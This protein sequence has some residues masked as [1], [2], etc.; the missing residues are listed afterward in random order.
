MGFVM[1]GFVGNIYTCTLTEVFVNLTEVFLILTEGFPCL[2]LC[3]KANARVKLAKKGHGPHSST[4][5]ICVVKL[6]F[7]SF[8]VLFVCK[9]ALP[10][11]G[12]P[13]AVNKYHIKIINRYLMQYISV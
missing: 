4:L 9:C 13:N 8:C 3:C 6:L 10:A 2:F 7:V 12:N 11:S 5:F 1:W